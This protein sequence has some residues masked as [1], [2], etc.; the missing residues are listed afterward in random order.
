M[1]EIPVHHN[2]I[3]GEWVPGAV[4]T[5]NI[6]P[7]DTRD[8]IG[9]YAAGRAT[10]VDAAVDAA[11]RALPGWS[12]A[13]P[14]L[15]ADIL[16]R[17]GTALVQRRDEIGHLLSREEG[18]TLVEG[19]GETVRAGQIFKFFA[20]EALR[21][22]GEAL[23]S[24]R[25]GVDVEVMREPVGI[26]GLIT[27]WNFPIAIPAWKLA[28][29]LAFG[30]CVVLKPAELTPG[31]AHVLAALLDEAGCPAGV[32]NLVIV[33]G[34]W[35]GVYLMSTAVGAGTIDVLRAGLGK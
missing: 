14:Q 30:N 5:D 2:F 23:P 20:Q 11:G 22:C 1:A 21:L 24:V 18:K 26:V 27:P 33:K 35:S 4:M 16:D 32:F 25:A 19:I 31:C 12:D 15:R 29:A 13:S 8:R 17:V 7:S 34:G 28:P 3:G 6:N 10:D 9:L